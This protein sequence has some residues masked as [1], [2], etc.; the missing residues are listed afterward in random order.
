MTREVRKFLYRIICVISFVAVL[1]MVFDL[2]LSDTLNIRRIV[3]FLILVAGVMWGIVD[4]NLSNA[5]IRDQEKELKLY[6]LYIQPMEELVK[7]IRYRQHEYDNH[8][9]AILS[10]HLTV[11]NYEE[12]VQKQSTYIQQV[13]SDGMNRFLPLLRISDKVLAGFLYSKIVNAPENIIVDIEVKSH[14]IISG[15][16]EHSMIEIIG[17]L[18]DNAF[19][20]SSKEGG[21]VVICLDSIEDRIVFDIMNQFP[22]VSFEEMG[23]FFESVYSTKET[24]GKKRGIGLYRAKTL[25]EKANGEITVGQQ[26][27]EGNNYIHFQVTV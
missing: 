27:I 5:I 17:V 3:I 4:R 22:K 21:K 14:E 19:E 13:R 15:I 1:C 18:V 16:S 20:A 26:E 23:H 2:M 25:I 11:D 8:M 12:L 9:N 24:D 7:E 10:M 6:Q